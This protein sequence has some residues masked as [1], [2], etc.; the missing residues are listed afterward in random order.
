MRRDDGDGDGRRVVVMGGGGWRSEEKERFPARV[1]ASER[2]WTC[3]GK[4][5]GRARAGNR[6]RIPNRDQ[7][8]RAYRYLTL[9][10]ACIKLRITACRMHYCTCAFRMHVSGWASACF[11]IKTNPEYP[12]TGARKRERE[13]ERERRLQR[14]FVINYRLY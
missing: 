1:Q 14:A 13:G 12:S 4:P 7:G 3:D 10:T 5:G 9:G 6:G 11:R 2:G 8:A